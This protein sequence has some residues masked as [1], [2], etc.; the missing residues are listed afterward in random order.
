M[1]LKK[2]VEEDGWLHYDYWN[3]ESQQW[4]T[5]PLYFLTPPWPEL[6]EDTDRSTH[7]PRPQ[8]WGPRPAA[9]RSSCQAQPPACP[10]LLTHQTELQC[11]EKEA[12]HRN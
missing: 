7:E 6:E 4:R 1:R 5:C 9:N 8:P 2:N 11:S 10:Q 12:Q 3:E